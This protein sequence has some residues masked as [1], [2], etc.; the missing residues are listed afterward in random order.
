MNENRAISSFVSN[1]GICVVL[2]ASFALGEVF[3]AGAHEGATGI[4]KERMESMKSISRAGKVLS[5]MAKGKRDFD[6]QNARTLALKIRDHAL[7]IPELFPRTQHSRTGSETEASPVIWKRWPE[8]EEL[9]Q[10]LAD[11][12][13]DLAN[14][15]E[16]SEAAEFQDHFTTVA[17]SCRTCHKSF[18]IKKH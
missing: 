6:P 2:I 14:V 8:F 17:K 13:G 12:S 18:R 7:R 15:A 9:A 16:Q 10:Q 1:F 11:A 4:V 5:D 3:D